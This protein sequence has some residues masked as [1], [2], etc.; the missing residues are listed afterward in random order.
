METADDDALIRRYAGTFRLLQRYDE[1]RL[2]PPAGKA[3]GVLPTP[4]EARRA[5]ARLKSEL[6]RRGEASELFGL[7]R[8]EALAALLGNLDQSVFGE[9]AYPSIEAKAA[10]LLY[11]I[12]KNHPFS[13]GNKRTAAFLFI[14]FLARNDRLLDSAGRPLIDDIGLTALTLLVAESDPRQKDRLIPLIMNLLAGA[15]E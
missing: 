6:I 14:H 9:P 2:D 11:F 12:I 1:D 8:G 4:Q 3:G 7:E 5:V 13:D 15:A 10:H